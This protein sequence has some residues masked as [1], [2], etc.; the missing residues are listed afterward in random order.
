MSLFEIK[1]D[2]FLCGLI[3]LWKS[4]RVKRTSGRGT[5]TRSLRFARCGTFARF[6]EHIGRTEYV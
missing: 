1:G 2:L 5:S 4:R 3:S 6:Q